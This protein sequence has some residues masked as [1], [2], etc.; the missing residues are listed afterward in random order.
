MLFDEKYKEITEN[1]EFLKL[2]KTYE[3]NLNL[4]DNK[5]KRT[6]KENMKLLTEIDK[7]R[8]SLSHSE[9]Y[10]YDKYGEISGFYPKILA[11]KIEKQFKLL[12]PNANKSNMLNYENG[13]YIETNHIVLK[14][15]REYISLK[16]QKNNLHENETLETIARDTYI[17][18]RLLNSNDTY[19]NFKN[20]LL[21]VNNNFAVKDHSPNVLTTIQINCNYNLNLS[22]KI[23]DTHFWKYINTSLSSEYMPLIR[24]MKNIAIGNRKPNSLYWEFGDYIIVSHLSIR[25]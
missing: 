25:N 6:K 22:R 16:D 5:L 8:N 3:K 13:V 15:I 14:K 21:D 12:T 11:N 18:S 1:R 9:F 17:D 19:I 4:M 23:K 20:C 10:K 2:K 7:L 24:P